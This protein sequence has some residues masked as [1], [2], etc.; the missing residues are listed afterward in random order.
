MKNRMIIVLG[1]VTPALL[2]LATQPAAADTST[3]TASSTTMASTAFTTDVPAL[4]ARSGFSS[5]L[6]MWYEAGGRVHISL[7]TITAA[8]IIELRARY[9]VSTDITQHSPF[10]VAVRTEIVPTSAIGTQAIKS[11]TL[12]TQPAATSPPSYLLDSAPYIG[13]DRIIYQS[14]S[15]STVS[16]SECTVTAPVVLKST[17]SMLTA[18]HC[19]PTGTQ[20]YQGYWDGN[21]SDP[22]YYSGVMGTNVG[23]SWGN[24][25][26]D[27]EILQ[28]SSYAPDI[29]TSGSTLAPIDGAVSPVIGSSVCFDGS[30]TGYSCGATVQ[31]TNVCVNETEGSTTYSVCGLD[32]AT[33]SHPII[34]SGD[35]G[36]PV[37]MGSAGRPGHVI[38]SGTISAMGTNEQGLFSD[39]TTLEN[40]FGFTVE[41]D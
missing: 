28:G 36:G 9:G 25:R 19:S 38:L 23:T 6:V 26:V 7:T 10:H 18:G 12:L 8:D 11:T 1:V 34:Q 21:W 5:R 29:W 13:G 2:V 24:N 32:Y 4:A 15:G 39:I 16:R 35:S 3:P 14:T 27:G 31:A 17:S 22:V 37:V 33:A 41:H 20:W 30:F 40:A